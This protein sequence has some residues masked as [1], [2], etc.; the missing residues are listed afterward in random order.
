MLQRLLSDPPSL[1]TVR[2]F[3]L[4][5]ALTL[6]LAAALPTTGRLALVGLMAWFNA[7]FNIGAALFC[8][9]SVTSPHLNRWDQAAGFLVLHQA[10]D[11][12]A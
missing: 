6:V 11:L 8:H 4:V 1:A 5:L 3:A 9:E 10:I 2:H 12:L 7:A